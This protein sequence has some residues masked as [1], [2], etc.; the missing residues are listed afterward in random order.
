MSV[1]RVR[2]ACYTVYMCTVCYPRYDCGESTEGVLWYN[3]V[4]YA[5][6]NITVERVRCKCVRYAIHDMIVE[7]VRRACY[8]V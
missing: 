3:C 7:R 1:E 8:T 5:I 6:H 2:R 4:R